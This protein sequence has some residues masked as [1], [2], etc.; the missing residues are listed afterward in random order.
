MC[1]PFCHLQ[2]G[3]P[4]R[5]LVTIQRL[6]EEMGVTGG[7]EACHLYMSGC[8]HLGVPPELSIG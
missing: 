1:E 2:R 8:V 3:I 5:L 6:E 7:R 4:W